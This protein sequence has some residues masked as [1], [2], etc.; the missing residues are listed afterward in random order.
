MKERRGT[1]SGYL[2]HYYRTKNMNRNVKY[3]ILWIVPFPIGNMKKIL[4]DD[5][6][7][8]GSGNWIED[9]LLDLVKKNS[10]INLTV[11]TTDKIDNKVIREKDGIDYICLNY[12]R[13]TVGSMISNKYKEDFKKIIRSLNPDVIHIWGTET[14]FQLFCQ[15][16]INNGYPTIVTVQGIIN[17]ISKYPNGNLRYAEMTKYSLMDKMKYPIFNRINK[18]YNR[19]SFIEKELFKISDN[20][21]SE[22][23]WV[24]GYV[25][26]YN[27]RVKDFYYPLRINDY[28]KSIQWKR[29]EIDE[30]SI[31]SIATR[32]AHKG[33]H[34]LI[35]AISIVKKVYP[36]IKLVIP[37]NNRINSLGLKN[38]IFITPYQ[39]YVKNLI[40]ELGLNDN[41][42]F[43]GKL[44]QKEM[45]EYLRKSHVFVMPSIIENQSASLREA[46]NLGVPSISSFVGCIGDDINHGHNGFLYNYNDYEVLAEYII[47]ILSDDTISER[48]SRESIEKFEKADR[49][50]EKINLLSIYS[51]IIEGFK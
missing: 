15:E 10:N 7:D 30:Y 48:F 8:S 51:E 16:C 1:F 49:E 28:F 35:K 43:V 27:N 5:K 47:K 29:S 6:V 14:G 24:L 38:S 44:T 2:F 42:Y 13:S 31:F 34:Q 50:N 37:G 3:D 45:S 23:D 20:I 11:L 26:S 39:S 33:L 19:Q 46:M 12:G 36:N 18:Q 4:F 9:T 32:G 21:I 25:K 41:I 17:A 40:K 22:S